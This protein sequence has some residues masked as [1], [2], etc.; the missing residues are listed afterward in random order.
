MHDAEMSD[1][2]NEAIACR[3]EAQSFEVCASNVEALIRNFPRAS[4]HD[5]ND[6][7]LATQPAQQM[8]E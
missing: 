3:R 4:D 2:E 7:G 6:K 8:P 5:E 1:D